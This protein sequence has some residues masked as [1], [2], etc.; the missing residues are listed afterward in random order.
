MTEKQI[1]RIRLKIKKYRA[2]LVAE[3]KLYGGFHDGNGIR[4]YISDLYM[5]I[6]DYKGAITYKRWFDKNFP[7]DIGGPFLSLIWS[8]AFHGLDK[9]EETKVYAIDTAFQ[10]I[11]LHRLMLDRGVNKIDMYD[12][13][14]D[15]LEFA[16][17][18]LSGCKKIALPKYLDWLS[19]FIETNEYAEPVNRFIALNKLL[20][21]EKNISERELLLEN[22]SKLVNDNKTEIR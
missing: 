5:Q 8:I 20:K 2:V 1:E 7:D 21:D 4:Y 6:G 12:Q 16:K 11:Y 13:G 19:S 14:Y 18:L 9:L 3:K 17:S 10:N 22:I 15:I